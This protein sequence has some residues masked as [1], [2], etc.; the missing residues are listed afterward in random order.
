M[1]KRRGYSHFIRLFTLPRLS[2]RQ[3][4]ED[5]MPFTEFPTYESLPVELHGLPRPTM[6]EM[7]V[8][9]PDADPDEFYED[10]RR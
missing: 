10:C 9:S 5:P 4:K 2:P 8:W 3:Q 6:P 7:A 1:K